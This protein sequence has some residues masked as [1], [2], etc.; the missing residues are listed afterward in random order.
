LKLS[1][2]IVNWKVKELL[3]KCLISLERGTSL[4]KEQFETIVVDNDSRD[5]SL[6]MLQR[7]FQEVRV[8]TNRKNYG[9]ARANNQAFLQAK[10]EYILLLNPDTVLLDKTIDAM[11]ETLEQSPEL[12]VVGCRLQN[13]DGSLQRYTGGAFPN[14][15]NVACHHLFF[16]RILP[17]SLRPPSLFLENDTTED[18]E[19]D[20]ISGAFML[21]RKDFLDE[22]IFDE[23]F[24][25]YGEDM[26]LCYRIQRNGGKVLYSPKASILHYYGRSLKQQKGEI[27]LSPL[28]GLRTFYLMHNPRWKIFLFDL[29]TLS[30]YFLRWIIYIALSLV[31][32]GEEKYRDKI[33]HSRR[34]MNLSFK[35]FGKY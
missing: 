8:I 19:V 27:L 3:E 4:P 13:P 22:W 6:E 16:Q 28:K 5:R 34:Y 29:L 12:G 2:I 18:R 17:S 30:G 35:I 14:L 21:L 10:G 33:Y 31:Y 23:F 25:L 20:W 24:F 15:M 9:F 11:L 26:D 32:S 7:K 1:I